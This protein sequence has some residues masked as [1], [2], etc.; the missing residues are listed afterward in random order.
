[1]S[2]PRVR[3]RSSARFLE[4]LD[5]FEVGL[6]DRVKH[7]MPQDAVDALLT[8]PP[9]AWLPVSQTRHLS[10]TL[11]REVGEAECLRMYRV[12]IRNDLVKT[13]VI[14]GLLEA[15]IRLFG[16]SPIPFLRG[17]IRG[18]SQLYRDF[19]ELELAEHQD[20][21]AVMVLR[22]APAEVLQCRGY[23]L[24]LRAG[25]LGLLDIARV[26]GAVEMSVNEAAREV[27]YHA[28]W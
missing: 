19:G 21:H 14:R 10:E 13:P 20:T 25:I 3:V 24:S 15:T 4:Y 23:L 26:D 7:A 8:S 5:E 27:R 17:M 11:M 6:S 2:T 16:I 28:S 18:W 1:M 9:T 22:D 12:Y